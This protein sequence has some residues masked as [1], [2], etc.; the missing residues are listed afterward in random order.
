MDSALQ[1]D[2]RSSFSVCYRLVVHYPLSPTPKKIIIKK[3]QYNTVVQKSVSNGRLSFLDN[4]L[5]ESRKKHIFDWISPTFEENGDDFQKRN[6]VMMMIFEKK[7]PLR[8]LL[9]SIK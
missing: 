2:N 7:I 1:I 4:I 5:G 3:D 8:G 9:R 6:S